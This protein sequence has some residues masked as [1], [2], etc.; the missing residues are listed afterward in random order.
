MSSTLGV[1]DA[2]IFDFD[3]TLADS[4]AAIERAAATWAAEFGVDPGDQALWTGLPSEH[5][6][7]SLLPPEMFDAAHALIEKLEIEDVEDIVALPGAAA[8]LAAVPADRVSI[9]TSCSAPLLTSRLG[10]TG[11][12]QPTVVVTRDM[13][14]DGKPAP[15]TFVMAADLMG[16]APE[17]C[18]VVEDAPAGVAGGRAAGSRVLGILTHHTAE[19]MGADWHVADLS[20][21]VFEPTDDGRVAVRTI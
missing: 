10:A 21:V 20:A 9:A 2:I 13:V 7:R 12:R 14:A 17:R 4:T 6:V 18:L 8:A 19:E 15:D 16:F 3:G 1:F 5:M 11:L